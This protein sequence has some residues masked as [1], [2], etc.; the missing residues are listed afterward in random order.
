V[1]NT[2]HGIDDA[3]GLKGDLGDACEL[4]GL[5]DT[6]QRPCA[7]YVKDD[8]ATWCNTQAFIKRMNEYEGE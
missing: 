6:G 7:G 2:D 8:E 3:T 4:S 1:A 5:N